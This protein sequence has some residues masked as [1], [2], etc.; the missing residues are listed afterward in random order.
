MNLK[1]IFKIYLYETFSGKGNLLFW[2]DQTLNSLPH[3]T[4]VIMSIGDCDK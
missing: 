3:E 1:F 4:W 2:A